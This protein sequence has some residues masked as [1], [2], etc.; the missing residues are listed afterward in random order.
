M[1]NRLVV[2]LDELFDLQFREIIVKKFGYKKGVI[3]LA[4]N[5][6]LNNWI[7]ENK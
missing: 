3:K 2:E 7:V 4:V 5:E 6:A 1:T